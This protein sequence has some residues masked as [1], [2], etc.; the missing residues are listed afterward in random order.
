MFIETGLG[1]LLRRSR[2]GEAFPERC[3]VLESLGMLVVEQE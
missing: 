2:R 1:T 3:W